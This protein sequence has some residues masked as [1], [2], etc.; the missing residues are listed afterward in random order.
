MHKVLTTYQ[1]L[2]YGLINTGVYSCVALLEGVVLFYYSDKLHVSLEYLGLA[3]FVIGALAAYFAVI[4]GNASDRAKSKYRRKAYILLFGPLYAAG[5]FF[6]IGGFTSQQNA[7]VY[8]IISYSIQTIGY[9]G[10]DVVT[11]AWGVELASEVA[12]R[13]SLYSIS[14][15]CSFAGVFLGLIFAVLPLKI[16]AVVL[17]GIMV[18][19]IILAVLQLPDN[20]PLT[21]R[22]F[23]PT[24]ANM[25]SV[26]WNS[27]FLIYLVASCFIAILNTVP[28]LLMFFIKFAMGIHGDQIAFWYSAC[29]AVFVIMGVM[30]LPFMRK[31][32]D[33]FGTLPLVKLA[34][35]VAAA[36]GMVMLVFSY[37]HIIFIVIAFGLVGMFSTVA[38]VVLSII[39]AEC[40]DYDELLCGKK[41][42]SSYSGVHTPIRLFIQIAGGSI[43]LMLMSAVGFQDSTDD[44][45]DSSSSTFAAT[46]VLRMW[47]TVVISLCMIGAYVSLSYYK[48]DEGKHHQ[49]LDNI[50][51]RDRQNGV[52]VVPHTSATVTHNDDVGANVS[53]KMNTALFASNSAGDGSVDDDEIESADVIVTTV[54]SDIQRATDG[55]SL[56]KIFAGDNAEVEADIVGLYRGTSL[57]ARPSEMPTDPEDPS[58]SVREGETKSS[59]TSVSSGG[60]KERELDVLLSSVGDPLT[61]LPVDPPPFALV[62]QLID[63]VFPAPTLPQS[64]S[65]S[66]SA[67]VATTSNS[68]KINSGDADTAAGNSTGTDIGGIGGGRFYVAGSS[69]S[70]NPRDLIDLRLLALYFPQLLQVCCSVSGR[71]RLI[72]IYI[73][74]LVMSLTVCCLGVWQSVQVLLDE[75]QDAAYLMVILTVIYSFYFAYEG[76]KFKGIL[77][78]WGLQVYPR[79]ELDDMIRIV[80]RKAYQNQNQNVTTA[81]ALLASEHDLDSDNDNE[82]ECDHKHVE[83]DK[84][85]RAA[86]HAATSAL[87]GSGGLTVTVPLLPH[88]RN[89]G[90]DN[91][92]SGSGSN[93]G[94]EYRLSVYLMQR[95]AAT[96]TLLC[97]LSFSAAYLAVHLT[98]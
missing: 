19:A 98:S 87:F 80:V 33:K 49:I 70:K 8:Y 69:A 74:E 95:K 64:N 55:A 92:S 45:D 7:P 66:A 46:L 9:T 79:P 57:S 94:R 71:T 53:G 75:N 32:V 37:V 6:R 15:A 23:V 72:S 16:A 62:I 91:S 38:N 22:A 93:H 73:V 28:Q 90:K 52:L 86:D 2:V 50:A 59:G 30:V 29:V 82:I 36:M 58:A 14:T 11:Q 20:T 44:S 40:I 10:M 34:I 67:A 65:D 76:L 4:G 12:D 1:R 60:T 78:L 47:C 26:F 18:V 21:K 43:P 42:G 97:V 56:Q 88:A 84:T 61:G 39:Y 41:R 17:T 68:N 54:I 31:L 35:G 24:V 48:I 63:K 83:S 27:Q 13:N 77:I 85:D 89:S 51:E 5:L 3:N 96:R 81:E 25:T